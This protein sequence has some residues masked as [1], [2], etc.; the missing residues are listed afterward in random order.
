MFHEIDIYMLNSFKWQKI[1]SIFIKY[2]IFYLA[3]FKLSWSWTSNNL[4]IIDEY[5]NLYPYYLL[6]INICLIIVAD[7]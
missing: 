3:L 4:N 2:E 6:I 1:I 5:F 7:Y